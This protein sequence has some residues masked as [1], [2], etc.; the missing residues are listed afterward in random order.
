MVQAEKR[1][2]ICF[3]GSARYTFPLD[4]TT[5][6][7]FRLLSTLGE[8][9]VFGFS[10]TL[11]PQRFTQYAH[12]YAIPSLPLAGLTLY[13]IFFRWRYLDALVYFSI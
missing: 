6:K 13:R 9:F 10:R 12:F 5:E 4:A 2:K 7:K 1:L 8:L 11:R 3:L